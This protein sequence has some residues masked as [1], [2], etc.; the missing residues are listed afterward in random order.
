MDVHRDAQGR[1]LGEELLIDA[2]DRVLGVV[3]TLGCLGIVVDAKDAKAERFYLRY[4]F[5][6]LTGTTWPK[7][8]FLPI[9]TVRTALTR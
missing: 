4:G 6:P 9:A 5:T 2:F 7:R 8:M 1:G 3:D